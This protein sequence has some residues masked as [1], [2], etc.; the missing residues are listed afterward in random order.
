MRKAT[1]EN[2]NARRLW[3]ESIIAKNLSATEPQQLSLLDMRKFCGLCVAGSFSAISYNALKSNTIKTSV[4][5]D[6]GA[7]NLWDLFRQLRSQALLTLGAEAK[8]DE[9][10]T[11]PSSS[12]DQKINQTIIANT[13][14]TMAYLELTESIIAFISA[15]HAEIPERPRTIIQ[16]IIA[17][18]AAK[19]NEILRPSTPHTGNVVTLVRD[20]S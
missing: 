13:I 5:T 16:N 18:N 15:H 8:D 20:L 9:I 1:I 14:I 19:F 3:L 12:T 10:S 17:N 4:T 11:S 2:I 6:T 7:V